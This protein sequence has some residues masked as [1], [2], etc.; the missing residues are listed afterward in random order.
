MIYFESLQLAQE[1]FKLGI[2]SYY[3][4]ITNQKGKDEVK[5]SGVLEEGKRV[6]I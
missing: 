5:E 4:H 3:R 6:K 1:D 2:I